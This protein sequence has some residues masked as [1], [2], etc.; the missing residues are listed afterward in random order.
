MNSENADKWAAKGHA[1]AIPR[2][3]HNKEYIYASLTFIKWFTQE[4]SYGHIPEENMTKW[5]DLGYNSAW[6]NIY[7]S[8]SY[9]KEIAESAVLKGLGDPNDVIPCERLAY[10]KKVSSYFNTATDDIKKEVYK[11]KITKEEIAEILNNSYESLK[12]ELL[13]IIKE[14]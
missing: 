5:G 8:E 6:K 7:R 11:G 10:S 4:Q 3:L 13:T 2:S 12:E 9:Q 1:F 14:K